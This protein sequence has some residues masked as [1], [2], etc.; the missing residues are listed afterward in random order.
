MDK[1][2]RLALAEEAV[3]RAKD[4]INN[5]GDGYTREVALATLDLITECGGTLPPEPVDADVLLAREL[6]DTWTGVGSDLRE[7]LRSAIKHG[8]KSALANRPSDEVLGAARFGD[9]VVPI[10]PLSPGP[11]INPTF[12]P[13]DRLLVVGVTGVRGCLLKVLH[14]DGR[15]GM[16]AT[17][18]FAALENGGSEMAVIR[19]VI[20]GCGTLP[21]CGSH[22]GTAT[23]VLFVVMGGIAGVERAGWRGFLFGSLVM[24]GVFGPTYL[25]GAYSRSK[26]DQP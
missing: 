22:P 23:L 17:S 10:A 20:R 18:C 26:E 11:G 4:S 1:I 5:F 19:H 9:F 12:Y 8:R 2:N 16:W 6:Y 14:E 15:D 25:Y 24:L 7:I 21:R 13:G 3:K